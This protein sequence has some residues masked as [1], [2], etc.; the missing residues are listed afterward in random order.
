MRL[1]SKVKYEVLISAFLRPKQYEMQN[2][3]C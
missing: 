1:H 2:G 3:T